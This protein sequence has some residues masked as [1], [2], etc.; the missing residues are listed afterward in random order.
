DG[1]E[2]RSGL[3]TASLVLRE[4][5]EVG[6]R[7]WG[8]RVGGSESSEHGLLEEVWGSG[9]GHCVSR[10]DVEKPARPERPASPTGT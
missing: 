6:E 7:R 8:G 9:S 5:E 1:S 4:L 3:W 10:S 2:L